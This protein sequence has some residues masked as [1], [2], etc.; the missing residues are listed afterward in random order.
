MMGPLFPIRFRPPAFLFL[1]F[2]RAKVGLMTADDLL[3]MIWKSLGDDVLTT[4]EASE[5]L[6]HLFGYRC[7]DDLAQTLT[8]YRT[9]GKIHGK[10]SMER[11]GW[12]WWVDDECRK[13]VQ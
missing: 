13:G 12:V 2:A 6:D 7:P 5:R 3:P 8:K 11:G 4:R 1:I 10:I 9:S